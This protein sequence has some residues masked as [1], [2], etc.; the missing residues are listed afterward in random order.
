MDLTLL[1]VFLVFRTFLSIYVASV[2]GRIVKSILELN[3]Q[4][5]IKR[6]LNLGL[7]AIP[8]SFVNSYLEFLNKRLSIH[9]RS[10]LT[11]HFL[12][13]YLKDMI[14]YQISNLDSRIANPDQRLTADI[15]KWS[16]SLS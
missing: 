1:S 10:R 16:N 5:F 6:I 4:L 15:E 12:D 3:L 13:I 11:N 14:Y 9:F 2:N 7:I 8:A